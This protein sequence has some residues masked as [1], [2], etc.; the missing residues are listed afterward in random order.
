[1][2]MWSHEMMMQHSRMDKE[3]ISL[4][5]QLVAKLESCK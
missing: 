2:V 1:M 4:L 3:T 5:D